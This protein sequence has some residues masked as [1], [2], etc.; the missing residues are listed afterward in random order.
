M[1][2]EDFVYKLSFTWCFETLLAVFMKFQ[3]SW[4]VTLRPMLNGYRRF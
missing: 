4:H 2:T 3:F 1:I